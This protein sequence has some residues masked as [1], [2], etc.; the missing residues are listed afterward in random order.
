MENQPL[1]QSEIDGFW[2][3]G[4]LCLEDAISADQITAVRNDF[5]EWL[6]ESKKHNE[7]FGETIDGRPRFDLQPEH[8]AEKP[9]TSGFFTD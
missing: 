2:E 8:T 1:N 7:P 5:D 9:A 3:N 4:Y 6:E